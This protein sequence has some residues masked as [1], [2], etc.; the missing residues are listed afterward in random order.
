MKNKKRRRELQSQTA[1]DLEIFR[2]GTGDSTI[3]TAQAA[4]SPNNCPARNN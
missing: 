3:L 4:Y 1:L 2:V